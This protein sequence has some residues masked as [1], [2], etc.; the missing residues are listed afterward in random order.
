MSPAISVTAAAATGSAALMLVLFA[1][2]L[3]LLLGTHLRVFSVFLRASCHL[4]L[5]L[6]LLLQLKQRVGFLN[7]IHNVWQHKSV[8]RIE[9]KNN[10]NTLPRTHRQ[11][12]GFVTKA[13]P[14]I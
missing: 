8:H 10:T 3:L 4:S 7:D 12:N 14:L 6:L 2:L 9:E 13:I 1:M 5:H 11:G